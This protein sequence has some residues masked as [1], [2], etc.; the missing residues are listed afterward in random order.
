[1]FLALV[2]KSTIRRAYSEVEKTG[3]LREE[4]RLEGDYTALWEAYIQCMSTMYIAIQLL[5]L[6]TDIYFGRLSKQE[7]H[8]LSSE[9]VVYLGVNRGCL[10][11]MWNVIAVR[12]VV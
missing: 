11:G 6:Y 4:S 8:S 1:M 3:E 7:S 10:A 5:N 9:R 2:Q 12:S